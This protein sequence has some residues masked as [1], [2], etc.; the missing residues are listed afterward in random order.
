MLIGEFIMNIQYLDTINLE[1]YKRLINDAGWKI[2]SDKQ[3]LN[4][5]KNSMFITSCVYDGLVVD[6]LAIILFMDYYVM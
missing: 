1:D 5:I 6:L 2:L 4:S 3:H